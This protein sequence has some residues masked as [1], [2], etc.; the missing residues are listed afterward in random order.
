MQ[1]AAERHSQSYL[2]THPGPAGGFC[3]WLGTGPAVIVAVSPASGLPVLCFKVGDEV[4]GVG[5]L[6]GGA[7]AGALVV[8]QGGA[9]V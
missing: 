8:V 1:A 2:L 9:G 5:D 7:G 3:R 6:A 4:Q